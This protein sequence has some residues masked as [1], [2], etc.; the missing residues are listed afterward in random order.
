[1]SDENEDLP[2]LSVK[3]ALLPIFIIGIPILLAELIFVVPLIVREF[4]D[5]DTDAAI[6]LIVQLAGVCI[7]L[8]GLVFT[9]INNVKRKRIEFELHTYEPGDK[10]DNL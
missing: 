1:M 2:M 6:S 8:A 5:K 7:V 10:F 9:K 4:A 3:K